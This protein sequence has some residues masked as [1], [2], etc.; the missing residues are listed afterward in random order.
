VTLTSKVA[1][2]TG[3]SS[4]LG[5]AIVHALAGA[6]ASV[7]FTFRSNP[8]GAAALVAE[9][10]DRGVLA[11]QGDVRSDADCAKFV[12][13]TVTHFGALDIIVN[14]AGITRDT[15][16]MRMS[17]EDWNSVVDTNL[18]GTVQCCRHALP[19]LLK[20]RA[21]RIIN[22]GSIA[23]VVGS[24]GQAN[25]SA[26]KAAVIGLTEVLSRELAPK[27]LTVNTVAPGAIDTGIVAGLPEEQRRRL[28]DVIPMHRMGRAEEVAALVAFLCG[29]LA[30]YITG[31]TIAVDGGTSSGGGAISTV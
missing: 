25:Y 16:A 15:L 4:G 22:I 11:I 21:G 9:L 1:L 26:A 5:R 31:Q 7:A 13:D 24:A 18:T 6:G 14:N 29:D 8:Q 12:G 27:A 17:P 30:G 20:S 23:G 10:A 2:V 19:H 28:I 3:G